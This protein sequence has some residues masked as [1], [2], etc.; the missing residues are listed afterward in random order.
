M[1]RF[2][3]VNENEDMT[4]Q[5]SWDTGKIVVS[6]MSAYMK[7]TEKSQ[8]H[9]LMLPLKL[10]EK[11]EKANPKTSR[12]REII[13]IKSEINEMQTNKQNIQ[14]IEETKSWFFE[15]NKQD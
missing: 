14:R 7:R 12:R 5:N 6:A 13:K 2:L 3:E 1:K 4:Y 8:I 10:L 15:R 11:Q 9:D